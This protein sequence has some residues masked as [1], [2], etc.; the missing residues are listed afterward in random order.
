MVK[1][2]L[3]KKG[4]KISE[5]KVKTVKELAKLI[6]SKKTFLVASTFN[7]QSYQLQAIRKKLRG[8]AEVKFVKKN[9]ALRAIESSKRE[10]IK[11]ISKY[12][13][14]S[15]ALIISDEDAYDLSTILSENQYPARAK[16]GQNAKTDIVVSEG[17]TDLMPGAVL[18]ELANVGLKAGIVGGKVTIKEKHVLV[19][20]GD[21]ITKPASDILMKLEITPFTIELEPVA[22]YDAS[23]GKVYCGLKIDKQ[24]TLAKLK[25]AFSSAFQFAI[26]IGYPNSETIGQIL[27]NAEREAIA[28]NSLT[29]THTTEGQ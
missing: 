10:G 16:T 19:K 28:M 18:T 20:K 29:T 22:A 24:A 7:L 8:K 14:E 25:E 17:P 23:S 15:P 27:I 26:K 2:K 9:V 4:H 3:E 6:D 21:V 12:V 13:T 11:E 1:Q 5:K